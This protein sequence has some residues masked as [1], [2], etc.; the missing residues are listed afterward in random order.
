[1]T[2]ALPNSSQIL[3][4]L[5]EAT[6]EQSKLRMAIAGP[7]GSGKTFSAIN[8]LL[9]MGCENIA[10]L[11]TEH[12]SAAKYATSFKRKF[13]VIDN[14]YWKS[15][16]DPRRL[17]AALKALA[18]AGV[19]G[20]VTDSLSH[21]WM[22]P[23]GM[24]QLI[25]AIALKKANGNAARKDTW[26]A[27]NEGDKI[28]AELVQ[29]ILALPCHFIATLRAKSEYE[30]VEVN[31]RKKKQKVGMQAQVREGFEYEFDV[32]GMMTMD[33]NFVVGKTRCSSLDEQIFHKPGKNIA[34]PLMAWLTDG[35]APAEQSTSVFVEEPKSQAQPA[36]DTKPSTGRQDGSS[37][38]RK[39][40]PDVA[41]AA[42]ELASDKKAQETADAAVAKCE[43]P[44][45]GETKEDPAAVAERLS[46]ELR[47]AADLEALKVVADKIRVHV[48]D[49]SLDKELGYPK[50]SA[51]YK[52]V[53][54]ALEAKAR[55][56]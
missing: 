22:G 18:A 33:H 36:N 13:K 15:N 42:D 43:T 53:K 31:G 21:F 3:D 47:G 28:Y 7:S 24:L 54:A 14:R 29:T 37:P 45:V 2:N 27:W 12:G 20:I 49:G 4:F 40:E 34:E 10:V 52:E 9:E 17:S 32:E 1:M 55:V 25:D 38:E 11:D 41:K 51:V 50:C 46:A 44:E 6:K 8:I 39:A 5:V 56:A 16:F 26:G 23:G 35:V 48:Q 19:D 30:D